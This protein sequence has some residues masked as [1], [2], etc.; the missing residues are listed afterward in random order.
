M[1]DEI[2]YYDPEN[3]K[4]LNVKLIIELPENPTNGD[5]L[6]AIF[7][8]IT[9]EESDYAPLIST[10]L[11]GSLVSFLAKWWNAPYTGKGGDL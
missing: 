8:G 6:Q 11:D 7:A 1:N 2:K 10:N 9:A 5:V 4:K 3:L